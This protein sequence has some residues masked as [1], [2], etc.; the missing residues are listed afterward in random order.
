MS[1]GTGHA[2]VFVRGGDT[3]LWYRQWDGA[4]ATGW[5]SLSGPIT[6]NPHPVVLDVGRIIVFARGTNNQV[7]YRELSSGVWGAWT[8]L[9]GVI[10]SSPV[11]V[12]WDPNH[13]AVFARGQANDLWY[14]QR[15][16]STWGPWTGLGGSFGTDPAVVSR[17]AGLIDVFV[18]WTNSTVA[19]ISYNG[20]SWSAW[21]TL[22][23]PPNGAV[24]EPAAVAAN[25]GLLTALVRSGTVFFPPVRPIW[26]NTSSDGGQTWSGWTEVIQFQEPSANNPEAVKVGLGWTF[27]ATNFPSGAPWGELAACTGP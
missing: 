25:T 5:Q 15:I 22:N 13:V 18:R 1:W 4:S 27:A 16:G 11:A 19:K 6:W 3:N 8:S 24:S 23:A 2:A 12:S 7:W 17:G 26:R 20:A 14:R 10:T 21:Q 9:G